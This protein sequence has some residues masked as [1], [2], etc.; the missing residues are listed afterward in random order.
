MSEKKSN[1]GKFTPVAFEVDGI[2]WSGRG[3]LPM[4]LISHIV[5]TGTVPRKV[6][7]KWLLATPETDKEKALMESA[8][9]RMAKAE[10]ATA[11]SEEP[12]ATQAASE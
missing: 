2:K 6:D 9:E 8:V 5:K 1:Q 11:A 7:G 10:A 3:R 12:S 4:D